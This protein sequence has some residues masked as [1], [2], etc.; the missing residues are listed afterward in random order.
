MEKTTKQQFNINNI[1]DQKTTEGEKYDDQKNG[2]FNVLFESQM[3]KLYNII[4][5]TKLSMTVHLMRCF[6]SL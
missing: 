6:V 4:V 5:L 2:F 3:L 1:F